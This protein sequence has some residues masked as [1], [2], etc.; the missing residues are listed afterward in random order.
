MVA[1]L[2]P[3][4][5]TATVPDA[6][7]VP[8]SALIEVSDLSSPLTSN[9]ANFYVRGFVGTAD[10]VLSGGIVVRGTATERAL[11]RALGSDLGKSGIANSL[12]N[13]VLEVRDNNGV[14][15]ASND[16]WQDSSQSE[17]ISSIGLAPGN[18][19]YAALLLT[20]A[21]GN[22]TAVVRGAAG[23]TG[24]AQLETKELR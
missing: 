19:N 23:S 2:P 15:L 21:P 5:Y 1:T 7:N 3:G 17:E 24:V 14:L 20:L 8:G 4:D 16:N 10:E 18:E 11:F 6:S 22:Y 13:P 12:A 9:F